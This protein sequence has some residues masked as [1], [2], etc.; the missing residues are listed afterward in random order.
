MFVMGTVKEEN[1]CSV[2]FYRKAVSR[3]YEWC[4][5]SI[6]IFGLLQDFWAVISQWTCNLKIV[7]N[8][9]AICI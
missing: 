2:C 6:I 1:E 3:C 8:I 7:V 4:K 9:Q 5:W